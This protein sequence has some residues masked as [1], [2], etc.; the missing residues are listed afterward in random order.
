MQSFEQLSILI[1][2]SSN[3]AVPL[4]SDETIIS[5]Y[6]N[7]NH[8]SESRNKT[9]NRLDVWRNPLGVLLNAAK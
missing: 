8:S 9:C 7:I 3:Q 1:S 2:S 6:L 5:N 4:S